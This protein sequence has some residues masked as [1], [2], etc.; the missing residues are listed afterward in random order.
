MKNIFNPFLADVPIL[1]PLKKPEHL[2]ENFC[3][4]G[5]FRGYEMG[6]LARNWLIMPVIIIIQCQCIEIH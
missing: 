6:A 2:P 3:F 5:I 4:S 1:C